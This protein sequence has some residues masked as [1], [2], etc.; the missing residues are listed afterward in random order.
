LIRE[1]RWSRTLFFLCCALLLLSLWTTRFLP[2]VDLPQYAGLLS[3][4]HRFH[5]PQ[6][7]YADLYSLNFFTPYMIGNG[8]AWLLS[9]VLPLAIWF[10]V[11]SLRYA[12]EPTRQRGIVLAVVAVVSFWL[13]VLIM[14]FGCLIGA[15]VVVMR[16][17]GIRQAL[18]RCLPFLI[19][20]PLLIF[21]VL[22]SQASESQVTGTLM[23][24]QLERFPLLPVHIMGSAAGQLAETRSLLYLLC[25]LCVLAL[26]FLTGAV[27]ARQAWRW[28]PLVLCVGLYLLSP[29]W[30][31]GTAWVYPRFAVF[32]VPLLLAGSSPNSRR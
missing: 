23:Q 5:D 26:P 11:L 6:F 31:F 32:V 1:S 12:A 30:I 19:P 17:S 20:A 10:V 8:L 21:W 2:M 18:I 4:L 28:S 14:G 9:L 15:V 29:Y 27:P 16:S 25:G 22:Q 3:V 7:G 13:H 24:W